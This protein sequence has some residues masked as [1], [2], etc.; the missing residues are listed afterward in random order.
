M[1]CE[2]AIMNTRGIA[3][4]ADSALTLGDSSKVYYSAEKL[5]P[6]AGTAPIAMLTYGSDALMG[7]PWA[8]II[9]NYSRQLGDRRFDRL[10]EYVDDFIAF[11]E[12]ERSMFPE[13]IQSARFLFHAKRIWRKI[14]AEPW[15]AMMA[16]QQGNVSS[17][18]ARFTKSMIALL[19]KDHG[20]WDQYPAL[21][22]RNEFYFSDDGDI[23]DSSED[24][25]EE[26][27]SQNDS[28]LCKIEN[29]LFGNDD[30]PFGPTLPDALRQGLRTTLRYFLLRGAFGGGDD[31]GIVFAG[32][33]E[34]EFYPS[35]LHYRVGTMTNNHLK[36]LLIDED[37]ITQEK[38]GCIV[39]LAQCDTI[40]LIIDGIHPD[41]KKLAPDLMKRSLPSRQ[42]KSNLWNEWEH[43]PADQF[44]ELLDSE[45][46][47]NH[48]GPFLSAVAAL[49]RQEMAV[50]AETL[51]NLAAF[52]LKFSANERETIGGPIDVA[53]LSKAEGFVW[54]KHK[55][56]TC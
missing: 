51:V 17:R 39:P 10:N 8:T 37:R 16:K 34:A 29:E 6:L 38:I 13:E 18:R 49:P 28:D 4:A 5:F 21:T 54:A 1:T 7:V 47:K 40:H 3:L 43:T 26:I 2:I 44:R 46:H 42:T 22:C 14:Y 35:V 19:Y 12:G 48:S 30:L 33:G 45:T 36:I 52:R 56:L 20:I 41:L 31:C 27:L 9:A 11:I 32:M 53:V 50:M 25:A 55:R 23:G 15:R 24:L